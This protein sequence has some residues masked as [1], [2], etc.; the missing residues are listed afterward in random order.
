MGCFTNAETRLPFMSENDL[1]DCRA[2][3]QRIIDELRDLGQPFNGVLNGG[4]FKT[5]EGLWV[6]EFNARFGDPEGLNVLSVLE[7]S[8]ADLLRRIWDGTVSEDSVSFAKKASVVKY[9]VAKEYPGR[10][11]EV[12]RIHA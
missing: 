11:H 5:R 8:L 7:G 10:K 12:D 3:M 4:F 6:M 9:L 1:V 2:I